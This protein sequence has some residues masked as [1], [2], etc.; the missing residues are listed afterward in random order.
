[1]YDAIGP[2]T[3]Q[4]AYVLWIAGLVVL[5]FT[6]AQKLRAGGPRPQFPRP[7]AAQ[8]STMLAWLLIAIFAWIAMTRIR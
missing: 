1:M 7:T 8:L 3:G 4:Y 6:L 5:V 2:L